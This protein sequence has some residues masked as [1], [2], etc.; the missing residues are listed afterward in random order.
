V[1]APFRLCSRPVKYESRRRLNPDAPSH[2]MAVKLWSSTV[3][4]GCVV[5]R[6]PTR[7]QPL[8]S[9]SQTASCCSSKNDA[10]TIGTAPVAISNSSV[11]QRMTRGASPW[12][13]VFVKK[14]ES[15]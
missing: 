14:P 8:C 6:M 4:G 2:L 12:S 11:M 13:S 9:R 7:G 15:K 5:S 1:C 10:S 3:Y